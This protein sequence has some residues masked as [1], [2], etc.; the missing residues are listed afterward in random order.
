[1]KVLVVYHSIYGH[2]SQLAKAV[3]EGLKSV[4]GVE[5]VFRRAPEFPHTEKE[6]EA[7]D[8]HASKIWQA[9]KNT[10][11]CTLDDLREADGLLLGA[12]SL[13]QHDRANESAH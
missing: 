13:W 8:G 9:Q 2:V 10:P 7:G 1:M 5:A 3:E 6:L 11:P 12:Y 4:F